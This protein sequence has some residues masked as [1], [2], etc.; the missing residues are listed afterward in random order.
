MG[1]LTALLVLAQLMSSLTKSLPKTSYYKVIDYW[2]LF[3]LLSTSGNIAVHVLVDKY[4]QA[5][6]RT[7]SSQS[8]AN[9]WKLHFWFILTN[10][11]P[12]YSSL[13]FIF[14]EVEESSSIQSPN[15]KS[16]IFWSTVRNN[17]VSTRPI[18][19]ADSYFSR[20]HKRHKSNTLSKPSWFF[21]TTTKRASQWG[22]MWPCASRGIKTM[23]RWVWKF[24]FY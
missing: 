15:W 5:E 7:K 18:Y 2:L 4:F 20:L 17:W 14:T 3:F 13:F 9:V 8:I 11:Q 19:V 10:Q 16:G 23:T 6:E 12:I 22:I 21:F 1:S 24:E